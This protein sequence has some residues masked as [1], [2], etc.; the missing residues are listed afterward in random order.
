MTDCTIYIKHIFMQNT[1]KLSWTSYVKDKNVVETE[2]HK[3]DTR[4]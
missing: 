2:G 4:G 1:L 3:N